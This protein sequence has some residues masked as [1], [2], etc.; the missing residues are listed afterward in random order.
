MCGEEEVVIALE[1]MHML[2]SPSSPL[3]GQ[4]LLSTFALLAPVWFSLFI[5]L[6][7]TRETVAF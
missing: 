5:P 4:L 7:E 1:A 2:F 3:M 6:S